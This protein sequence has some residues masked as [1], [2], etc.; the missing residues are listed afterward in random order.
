M[1]VGNNVDCF[2]NNGKWSY[3]GKALNNLGETELPKFM[4]LKRAIIQSYLKMEIALRMFR[5]V[6]GGYRS[7]AS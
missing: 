7:Y 5:Q 4:L 2:P 3:C 1:K 6:R